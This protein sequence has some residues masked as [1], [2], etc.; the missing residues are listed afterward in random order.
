MCM[1]LV[2]VSR[3]D[4][5]YIPLLIVEMEEVNMLFMAIVQVAEGVLLG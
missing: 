2:S 5:V 3:T 4:M 1:I